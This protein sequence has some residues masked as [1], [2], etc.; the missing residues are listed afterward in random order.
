MAFDKFKQRHGGQGPFRA[1]YEAATDG[2]GLFG[3]LG[4]REERELTDRI[5]GQ[6]QN[7]DDLAGLVPMAE[8]GR[9]PLTRQQHTE[10]RA[11]LMQA[12][13][14][15]KVLDA[16]YQQFF[17]EQ[18]LLKRNAM[19][20]DDL[21]AVDLMGSHA[22]MANRYL[23]SGD[24]A[25]QKEGAG[26]MAEVRAQ[27]RAM[28]TANEATRI[29]M[30][31]AEEAGRDEIRGEFQSLVDSQFTA[32][33]LQDTAQYSSILRQ[34]EG[35]DG[36]Q[37]AAPALTTMVLDY[38]GASLRQSDDGNWGFS[39]GGLSIGDKAVPDMTY[40]QLRNQ[41]NAAR[42]GRDQ[43]LRG[44]LEHIGGLAKKRGFG[45]NGAE[46]GDL[47]FPLADAVYKQRERDIRPPP[48]TQESAQN[49]GKSAAETVGNVATGFARGTGVTAPLTDIFEKLFLPTPSPDAGLPQMRTGGGF[50][51]ERAPEQFRRRRVTND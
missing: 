35:G 38:A 11:G 22:E 51:G 17:G 2:T 41:L 30:Q 37:V 33:V 46:V 20:R 7:D 16:N 50:G 34:L 29:Q 36:E 40:S 9:A 21:D 43:Y 10:F 44:Q 12:A 5:I 3:R 32:P 1:F 23:R 4:L 47:L 27:Q 49:A 42:E 18:A 25:L 15:Q 6:V 14:N 45:I 28:I 19:G 39:F 13:L 8:A 48:V 24:P 31:G 26:M